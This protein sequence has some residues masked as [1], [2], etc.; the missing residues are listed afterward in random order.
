MT[1]RTCSTLL[2]EGRDSFT[3][4]NYAVPVIMR[5]A[6]NKGPC[7]V[8]AGRHRAQYSPL[9]RT[10]SIFQAY[11][12][13]R[14]QVKQVLTHEPR[15]RGWTQNQTRNRHQQILSHS[16][17]TKYSTVN[18][19][20]FRLLQNLKL[21]AL[22]FQALPDEFPRCRL[23]NANSPIS[24]SCTLPRLPHYRRSHSVHS[25]QLPAS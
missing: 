2:R 13:T 23:R 24:T 6:K 14:E 12:L 4:S 3:I 7:T 18:I 25:R 21:A 5:S 20:W 16:F 22:Q 9:H 8:L 10:A 17:S 11:I 19:V 1:S 15:L